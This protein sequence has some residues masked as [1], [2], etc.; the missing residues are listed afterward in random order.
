MIFTGYSQATLYGE[1]VS[2]D[3]VLDRGTFQA[4]MQAQKRRKM[5][6]CIAGADS[7]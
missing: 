4:Q 2:V 3:T 5:H 7:K 1:E 6:Q